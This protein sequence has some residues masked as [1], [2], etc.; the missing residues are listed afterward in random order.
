MVSASWANQLGNYFVLWPIEFPR[1]V[2]WYTARLLSRPSAGDITKAWTTFARL[3]GSGVSPPSQDHLVVPHWGSFMISS[4]IIILMLDNRFRVCTHVV[5]YTQGFN[6]E[7]FLQRFSPL[8]ALLAPHSQFWLLNEGV[9]ATVTKKSSKPQITSQNQIG[10]LRFFE[11]LTFFLI[12][13]TTLKI[14]YFHCF[15]TL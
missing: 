10:T 8:V 1:V 13:F 12:A 15:W 7:S 14:K 11:F 5:A 9:Q 3:V 4:I 2:V 6:L